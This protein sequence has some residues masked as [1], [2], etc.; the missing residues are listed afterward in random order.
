M[1]ISKEI[2]TGPEKKFLTKIEGKAK[3]DKICKQV[4]RKEEAIPEKK[5][6]RRYKSGSKK[7]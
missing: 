2:Q 7:T 1:K 5:M 6:A 3:K 4:Q